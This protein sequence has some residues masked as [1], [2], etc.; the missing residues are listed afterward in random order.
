IG[1]ELLRQ[2][3]GSLRIIAPIDGTPAA[4]AGIKAGDVIV[5][6]D[7]TP[8]AGSDPASDPLRGAPGTQVVL[9]ILREGEDEPLEVTLVRDTIRV[10]SVRSRLLE[11]G[12]GYVRI[13]LFQADTG[14]DF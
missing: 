8:V 4:R 9:T 3:D 10:A 12:Y 5:A 2:P 7:G 13:S 14:A 6:I 11:P 1:V